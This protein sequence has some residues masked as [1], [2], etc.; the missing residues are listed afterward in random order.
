[1]KIKRRKLS[2]AEKKQ[3]EEAIQKKVKKFTPPKMASC[4][5]HEG[6]GCEVAC[7]ADPIGTGGCPPCPPE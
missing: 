4:D 6:G 7:I 3:I 5:Y 1:M 2:E